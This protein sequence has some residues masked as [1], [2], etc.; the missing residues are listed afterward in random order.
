VTRWSWA[1]AIVLAVGAV[2]TVGVDFQRS[3][4]L[5][6]P[7]DQV[8]P[9]RIAGYHGTDL[10]LS[11]EE[12]SSVGVTNYLMRTFGSAAAPAFS[13]YVGYYARQMQGRAIH[14]PKNCLPGAGWE[15]LLARTADITTASGVVR[16]NRYLIRKGAERALVLY[17][18]QG[19]GRVE[20]NEYRV[21]WNLLQ[22]AA[23][24]GR[25]EEALV[26]IVVTVAAA[27]DPAFDLGARVVQ[28]VVPALT[29]ALP[30]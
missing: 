13:V 14:S 23:L 22:D 3:M 21:K 6:A 20:P 1:S 19:R 5:R 8:V 10:T 27:E 2:V 26:R 16:V 29:R 12:R 30:A 9:A 4:P 28:V 17:W 24:R 7:L 15:M 18:Y 25:T 11:D